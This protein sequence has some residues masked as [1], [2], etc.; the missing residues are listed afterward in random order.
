MRGQEVRRSGGQEVRRTGG[1]EVRRSG[2]PSIFL[3]PKIEIEFEFGFRLSLI[4]KSNPNSIPEWE[5]GPPQIFD[6]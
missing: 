6:F 3:F 1:Q 4:P 5:L 2:G